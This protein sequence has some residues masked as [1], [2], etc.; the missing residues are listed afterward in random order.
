ML[1]APVLA[2]RAGHG[3]LDGAAARIV[4]GRRSRLRLAVV[5]AA[6]D[7]DLLR[8]RHPRHAD[9]DVDCRF[10]GRPSTPAG[11]GEGVLADTRAEA[12]EAAQ[13]L[14]RPVGGELVV[15]VLV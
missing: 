11:N 14:L 7:D 5:V 12:V 3:Q 6:D 10:D 15:A 13:H 1:R 2:Y 8:V 4:E 9:L